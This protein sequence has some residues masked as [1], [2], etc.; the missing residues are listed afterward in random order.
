MYNC[1]LI[2]MSKWQLGFEWFPRNFVVYNKCSTGNLENRLRENTRHVSDRA[3]CEAASEREGDHVVSSLERE[4]LSYTSITRH[5]CVIS[6]HVKPLG[7]KIQLGQL[8]NV[9]SSSLTHLTFMHM[10]MHMFLITIT[11]MTHLIHTWSVFFLINKTLF[12]PD[13]INS[14]LIK[15]LLIPIHNLLSKT[16]SVSIQLELKIKH[17]SPGQKANHVCL[18]QTHVCLNPC[19]EV[20]LGTHC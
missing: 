7:I 11:N 18:N 9:W 20:T 8:W 1:I 19:L 17:S 2:S 5:P 10:F 12:L 4:G 3:T 14:H 6:Q 13:P 16:H 15:N